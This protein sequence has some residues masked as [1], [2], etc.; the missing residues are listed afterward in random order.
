[1]IRTS[2]VV[3]VAPEGPRPLTDACAP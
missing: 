2:A 3:T 1:M